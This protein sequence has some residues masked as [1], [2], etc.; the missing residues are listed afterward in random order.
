MS[1]SPRIELL[2]FLAVV[3]CN[4]SKV[5][6]RPN[7]DTGLVDTDSGQDSTPEGCGLGILSEEDGRALRLSATVDES[8]LGEAAYSF[9]YAVFSE[10]SSEAARLWVTTSYVWYADTH[11]SWEGAYLL[12]SSAWDGDGVLGSEARPTLYGEDGVHAV[13]V[14][15]GLNLDS[16]VRR[17]GGFAVTTP[18]NYDDEYDG[19]YI[20]LAASPPT[21]ATDLIAWSDAA[22]HAESG[23]GQTSTFADLDGDGLDDVIVPGYPTRIFLSPMA[24]SVV[25]ADAD[26][27]LPA[28]LSG[29]VAHFWPTSAAAAD[30][31]DDGYLDLVWKQAVGERDYHTQFDLFFKRGPIARDWDAPDARIVDEVSAL[32]ELSL[33]SSNTQYSTVRAVG[34]VSGDG[35]PDVTAS[36]SYDAGGRDGSGS[37]IVVESLPEGAVALEDVPTRLVGIPGELADEPTRSNLGSGGS[38]DVNGDGMDDL[39]VFQAHTDLYDGDQR[40]VYIVPG[41]LIGLTLLEETGA[42]IRLPLVAGA[43]NHRNVATVVPDLDGD[44]LD[45]VIVNVIDGGDLPGVVWLF[46]GCEQW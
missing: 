30:L 23:E 11:P 18:S 16:E 8:D 33:G 38:G 37:L 28:I 12:D 4:D 20:W 17:M 9:G 45:D 19:S 42:Q 32:P 3:A 40:R 10:R 43:T 41:P 14:A 34:D 1:S 21:R 46:A 6:P 7:P 13:M 29:G 27:A 36:F 26:V 5:H 25:D 2:F 39:V 31:D 35:R 22:I 24:G 15:T 44:G